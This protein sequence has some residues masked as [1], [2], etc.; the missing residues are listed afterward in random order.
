MIGKAHRI[1]EPGPYWPD[2]GQAH[3]TWITFSV[4]LAARDVAALRDSFRPAILFSNKV[5]AS[6][7]MT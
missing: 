4:A 6:A 7:G 3:T 2:T 1:L 5:E